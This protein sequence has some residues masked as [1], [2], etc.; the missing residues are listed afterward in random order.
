MKINLTITI[1]IFFTT[2]VF[3]QYPEDTVWHP[4]TPDPLPQ[5][6][7]LE[8]V[9]DTVHNI[10]ITRI[11]DATAFGFP[12]GAGELLPPYAKVQAWN[13]DMT[14]VLIGFT[15][16]L[17][18][19]DYTIYKNIRASYP[20]GFFNDARWSNV[21]PDIRYFCYGNNFLKLNIETFQVD[22]LHT[23][24][25]YDV[26]VGPWEGNISADDKYVVITNEAADKA[27]LYDIENDEIIS[28]KTFPAN[29][30]DWTSITPWN[31]YIAVSNNTTGHVELYD[32]DFNYLRDLTDDQQHADFAIDAN[33]NEVFVQ[34][35]PL[36]MTDLETGQETDLISSALVC[37]NYTFNPSLAGHI[38]G[39]NFNLPGWALVSTQASQECTN[40]L[41]YYSRT[42]MFAIKL[43][44]SG[45]IRHYGHSYTSFTSYD[46]ATKAVFSPDGTKVIFSSDWNLL[47]NGNGI[48]SA[49]V[50]EYNDISLQTNNSGEAL[51]NISIY[52]NPTND[53]FRI[54]SHGLNVETIEIYNAVGA[55]IKEFRYH[56]GY[57]VDV[58]DLPAG[59]YFIN[60]NGQSI[61]NQ[62]FS[63]MVKVN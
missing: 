19:D 10:D 7:Y 17:N 25:G 32:L 2:S 58:A 23:F 59:I 14:K 5:P 1:F 47:G 40:G 26:T 24:P 15:N 18:A 53:Y 22:T 4:T 60:I 48:V 8:T 31:D 30:F 6:G 11:S 21:D 42:E 61:E 51:P 46:S 56:K 49:Y 33:G 9:S 55:K 35:I 27:T 12:D 39:R 13:A 43:D 62:F 45:T 41:G 44:G 37:G 50:A 54:L 63:K 52:P 16:V 3:A 28:S 34:V 36:S 57:K 20:S 29:G 38:S